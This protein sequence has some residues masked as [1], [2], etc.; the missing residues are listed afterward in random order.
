MTHY[1]LVRTMASS[2]FLLNNPFYNKKKVR[3]WKV[4]YFF[5]KTYL[6]KKNSKCFYKYFG[7]NNIL[8]V[9]ATKVQ[10]SF[11]YYVLLVLTW[12]NSIVYIMYDE[13]T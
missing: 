10:T 9:E 3:F 2:T 5:Q 1:G 6:Q 8:S 12:N 11:M 7:K 4:K 13:V